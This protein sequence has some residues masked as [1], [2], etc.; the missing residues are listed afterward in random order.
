MKSLFYFFLLSFLF[1][2]SSYAQLQEEDVFNRAISE[3]NNN[4][5][6]GD[7]PQAII[8]YK[9]LLKIIE[10]QNREDLKPLVFNKL[11]EIYLKQRNFDLTQDFTEKV[12]EI[13]KNNLSKH[14]LQEAIALDIMGKI[15]NVK[16]A[17]EKSLDYH[18]R[19]LEIKETIDEIDSS[20]FVSSYFQFS[21]IYHMTGK[22]D[23]AK[24]YLN[25]AL[26]IKLKPTPKNTVLISGIYQ[27]FGPVSY[28]HL[29][30]PTTP[31][32]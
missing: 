10:K 12:F 6:H 14:K 16:R 21:K 3:A 26:K 32:V 19:A 7:Y 5:L 17:F 8:Q 1:S 29:T 11:A 27:G 25:K 30:L 20:Q 13:S 15:E 22:Y 18:T 4:V 31:Y 23:Q 24:A 2:I 9:A 28:T